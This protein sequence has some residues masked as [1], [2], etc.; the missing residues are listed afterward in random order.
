MTDE[1]MEFSPKLVWDTAKPHLPPAVFIEQSDGSFFRA[2]IEI[3]QWGYAQRY[4]RFEST[5]FRV[6]S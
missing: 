3:N 2:E 5:G 4:E 6:M 1:N